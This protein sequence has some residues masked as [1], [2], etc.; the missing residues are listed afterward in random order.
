[1]AVGWLNVADTHDGTCKDEDPGWKCWHEHVVK[2]TKGAWISTTKE[3]YCGDGT[4]PAPKGCTWRVL[5]EPQVITKECSDR[6]IYDRIEKFSETRDCWSQCP[7]S[8]LGDRRNESSPCWT[9]CFFFALLGPQGGLSRGA[10]GGISFDEI[11]DAWEQ[12]FEQCE[13][14]GKTTTTSTFPSPIPIEYS[15]RITIYHV[16]PLSEGVIPLNM[17]SG[18]AAGDMFFDFRSKVLPFECRDNP[19]APDCFNPEVV[20]E[21]LVISKLV[22]EVDNRFGLYARCNMCINGTDR[23]GDDHC[24]NGQYVC[25]CSVDEHVHKDCPMA[26][27]WLN[28]NDTHDGTCEWNDPEWKCWHEH[29]IK[30]TQGAW[31]STTKESYC[32]DGTR[33]PPWGCTWRVVEKPQVITKKCSD[34]HIYDRIESFPDTSHCWSTCSDSGP[35]ERRNES[36]L[37]WTKCFF[38]AFLG[39]EA[40]RRGGAVRGIEFTEILDAWEEAFRKCEPV[41]LANRTNRTIVV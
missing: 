12:A 4:E 2:K 29:V 40:G 11:V 32:G 16:N 41:S 15:E 39:R 5:E 26:V 22:L 1:M 9:K 28:V 6:T 34:K 18:D 10:I 24:T 31:V 7:D 13:P 25:S 20:G 35:G 8:G 23:H 38:Q 37:C 30:K 21:E 33:S 36:S 17:D 19:L 27:G 3:S 14:V